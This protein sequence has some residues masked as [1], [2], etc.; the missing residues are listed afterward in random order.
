MR[1]LL[2]NIPPDSLPFVAA[3]T[4]GA[5]H[6]ISVQ[7]VIEA[8]IIGAITAGLSTYVT[9]QVLDERM[10]SINARIDRIEHEAD[11]RVSAIQEDVRRIYA[12]LVASR[13]AGRT[14]R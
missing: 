5:A 13:P 10:K 14:E 7:R 6:R 12:L 9:V 2:E 4:A 8:V 3:S 1:R 11:R